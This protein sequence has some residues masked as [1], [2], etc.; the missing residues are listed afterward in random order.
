MKTRLSLL[1]LAGLVLCACAPA[2]EEE[3]ITRAL[4][5]DH[6]SLPSHRHADRLDALQRRFLLDQN[7][8]DQLLIAPW[9]TEESDV[10]YLITRLSDRPLT[11]TRELR[12]LHDKV[13]SA[14]AR[15]NSELGYLLSSL[16]GKLAPPTGTRCLYLAMSP[17]NA[18]PP[19]AIEDEPGRG[20][21]GA[22]W[23]AHLLIPDPESD[24]LEQRNRWIRHLHELGASRIQVHTLD[25][26]LE[27][28][29]PCR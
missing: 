21:H 18:G 6:E 3:V 16:A 20:R 12:L 15:S 13:R 9:D 29:P 17:S 22:G 28:L 7:P 2:S 19:P 27:Q 4:A 8:G 24:P 26:P 23:R 5:V 25:H 11:A 1:L 14:D 10:P